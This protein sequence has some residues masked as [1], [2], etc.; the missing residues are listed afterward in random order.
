MG[1]VEIVE[2][3]IPDPDRQSSAKRGYVRLVT[4]RGV[5]MPIN[6]V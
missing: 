3:G 2:E 6:K 4:V 1:F 5:F